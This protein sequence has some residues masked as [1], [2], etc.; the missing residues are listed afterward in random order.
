MEEGYSLVN[1]DVNKVTN[2][3]EFS[4]GRSHGFGVANFTN[5]DPN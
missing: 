1:W 4:Y 3:S 5:C 2:F